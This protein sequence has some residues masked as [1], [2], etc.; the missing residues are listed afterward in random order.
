[1]ANAQTADPLA[2]TFSRELR[3]AVES[4]IVEFRGERKY[5]AADFPLPPERFGQFKEEVVSEF[6]Q[7]L[8][9][10][11]W[12]VRSPNGKRSPIRQHFRDRVV[13]RFNHRGVEM[14]AHVVELLPTG[15]QVPIV[16]CL[17]PGEGKH[18]A[19]AAF[20]GHGEHPL[21]D[22][23]FGDESYQKAIAARLARS[24]FA[25]VAVEKVDSGYMSRHG[26]AGSDEKAITAF[27]LAM[28]SHVRA[29]Q[30]MATLA[31]VEILA[32]H[33][34]VDESRMGA[35]G[36][37]LGECLSIQ[38]ALLNDRIRA[39]AEYGTKTVFLPEEATADEFSGISD[40][41]HVIPETFRLGDR[42]L[43]LI[44]FAPKPLLSGH[45]GPTDKASH[46]QYERYYRAIYEDSVSG[47][48]QASPLP[49]PHSRR[50]PRD[51]CTNGDRVLQR[52]PL[53]SR[54]SESHP[55]DPLTWPHGCQ[56]PHPGRSTAAVSSGRSR[57]VSCLRN[58]VARRLESA[59]ERHPAKSA[60]EL[61]QHQAETPA[62]LGPLGVC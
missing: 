42:N 36:V 29:V 15:D 49:V 26:S 52:T 48:R 45:G 30:L 32:A 22:L 57:L 13:Q 23:V 1:M 28:G 24:G 33:P 8:H 12:V 21:H 53:S 18:P 16:L 40:L 14:E 41:C 9:L 46:G 20:P 3:S 10:E 62:G 31:A 4:L 2:G 38:T 7:A 54:A 35:T 56:R 59:A 44:P 34:R 17:P 19:V 43:L 60:L 39:V 55:H 6:I 11:D 50:R 51:S 58:S 25:S 61:E 47:A 5:K 37:S 27:R